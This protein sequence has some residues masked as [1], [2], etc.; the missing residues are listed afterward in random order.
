M[1]ERGRLYICGAGNAAEEA[2]VKA[3]EAQNAGCRADGR[4]DDLARVI[5]GEMSG[6]RRRRVVLLG[7]ERPRSHYVVEEV[8]D[9][10]A[11]SI[12]GVG[13][14]EDTGTGTFPTLGDT[15]TGDTS[16]GERDTS[17]ET[18]C[19][20]PIGI[21][22]NTLTQLRPFIQSTEGVIIQAIQSGIENIPKPAKEYSP[23]APWPSPS[24]TSQV[25][26]SMENNPSIH[27]LQ[28]AQNHCMLYSKSSLSKSSS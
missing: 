23:R 20:W 22:S 6:P 15:K 3:Y 18:C 16:G 12:R 26:T 14:W 11:W 5:G 28:E 13:L 7:V 17:I 19:H 2:P 4:E 27:E 21:S 10:G 9:F 25:N 1:A 8:Q 24:E